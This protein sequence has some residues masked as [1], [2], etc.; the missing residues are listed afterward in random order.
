VNA[1]AVAS[2]LAEN[3]DFATATRSEEL[4]SIRWPRR[5]LGRRRGRSTGTSGVCRVAAGISRRSPSDGICD[6]YRV[7]NTR[8]TLVPGASAC[9]EPRARRRKPRRGS[10]SSTPPPRVPPANDAA[11]PD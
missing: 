6:R 2:S 4:T 9:P 7:E 10:E 8:R 3:R 11:P 1:A 5:L